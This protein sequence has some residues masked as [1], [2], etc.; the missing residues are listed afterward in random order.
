VLAP[1]STLTNWMREFEHWAPSISV[2]LFH[3]DK[4][5]R[6]AIIAEKLQPDK[7]EVVVA[8][9]EMVSKEA[10]A[11][12]RFS[13]RY[14]IV[15]EAHRMK[16]E[17]SVLSQV[18]RSLSSHS[19]LLVTGTPLQNNLHELWALL[20]FL[21]P[22]IFSSA[23]QWREWF[24]LDDKEVEEEVISKLHKVLRPFLLRRVKA[25]VETD[26][27]PKRELL[28]SLGLSEMQREQYK[29]ILKRDID[30]L[31]NSTGQQLAANKGR[32]LNIVMQLRKCCNHPYLFEGVE[33]KSLPAYGEHLV[34]NSGK[35]VLLDKLLLRLRAE[36]HT[37][38]IFSQMT[39]MLDI[40]ED[41]C[42]TR[43]FEYCRID[44]NTGGEERQDQI[45]AFNAPGS[46]KFVFLLS[47]RAGG[48]GI[49]LQTADTVVLYD[50]DWNPQADLQA[51]DR[52]HRIGQR[53]QV[54]VYRLMVADSIE[55]KMIERAELKLR[56]DA[57]V[58]QQGRLA[59]KAKS[60][61]KEDA[62]QARAAQRGPDQRRGDALTPTHLR[63]RRR[64]G[65]NPRTARTG[66]HP[67]RRERSPVRA[68]VRSR[69][70][71]LP[72]RHRARC[73]D[74]IRS[75][76]PTR[77]RTVRSR[78]AARPAQAIRYGADKIFKASGS[79]VTDDDIEAIL[80][81]GK[82]LT[83]ARSQLTDKDKK[84]LLDFSSAEFAYQQF[85]GVDYSKQ[86]AKQ[87]CVRGQGRGAGGWRLCPSR[88]SLCVCVCVSV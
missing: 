43:E 49:N 48:L 45:D 22:D 32:L 63:I 82:D 81:R 21:L 28:L 67:A 3:G 64:R 60:M 23:D 19:R 46:D 79:D 47:T 85:D 17:Q 74:P 61:S 27:P 66:K 33:D 86:D 56:M 25:E 44:G 24:D 36:G 38:L 51:Q 57:A 77:S 1:K 83:T 8:S 50:S 7:F 35:M 84:G 5:E 72:L 41:Y 58:I 59:D 4:D 31:Y 70:P 9:Y 29:S 18:L 75:R 69:L 88:C 12:R 71:S 15:D 16:N 2:V 54:N 10:A 20:N 13:W 73:G 78:P 68:C 62:I 40:L 11:F 80:S 53:R 87:V 14:I 42:H 26:L 34:Q 30:A 52:A 55:E 39:R 76:I 6:A 37:C 65:P